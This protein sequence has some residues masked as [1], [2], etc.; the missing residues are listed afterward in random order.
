MMTA[1]TIG[2]SFEALGL[3]IHAVSCLPGE[4]KKEVR[5]NYHHVNPEAVVNGFN[6]SKEVTNILKR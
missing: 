1:K 3:L 6:V 2:S 5:L 4:A